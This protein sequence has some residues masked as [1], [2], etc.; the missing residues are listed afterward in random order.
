MKDEGRGTEAAA[1]SSLCPQ[2]VR[3]LRARLLPSACR[4]LPFAFILPFAFCLLPSAFSQGLF[5]GGGKRPKDSIVTAP[6][7]LGSGP[8]STRD[9]EARRN[10]RRTLPGRRPDTVPMPFNLVWG[11]TTGRLSSLFAGVGAKITNK[12][13]DGQKEIWTVEGL[14]APNLQTSLFTFQNGQLAALEF[15][16]S[17]PSWTI[18][19]Y[20]E[21]MGQFRRLLESKCEAPGELISRGPTEPPAPEATLKETLTGYQWKH[22]DTIVQLFYFSAEDSAKNETFRSISVHYHFADPDASAP[23]PD[24]PNATAASGAPPDPNTAA[25]AVGAAS[26]PDA[27]GANPMPVD[28]AHPAPG[29]TVT[30]PRGSKKNGGKPTPPA[31]GTPETDPLPE[32]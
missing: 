12:K 28:P 4:L 18:D 20:N 24:D 16:Y 1:P 29:V 32:H 31:P 22:G 8:A 27:A 9:S 10:P 19:Q 15:D 23:P 26:A 2:A 21:Q 14:I 13:T 6:Q 3:S 25:P 30:P 17:Q 7:P 11:D 5:P